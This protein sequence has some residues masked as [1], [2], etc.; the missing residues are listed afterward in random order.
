MKR[1]LLVPFG[2]DQHGGLVSPLEAQKGDPFRCPSCNGV[3]ILEKGEVKVAHCAHGSVRVCSQ[4]T[5]LH[6]TAKMLIAQTVREYLAACG[7]EPVIQGVCSVCEQT[8]VHPIPKVVGVE[9]EKRLSSGFVAGPCEPQGR[10]E[11]GGGIELAFL[12]W[13]QTK[14]LDRGCGY[15]FGSTSL[16]WFA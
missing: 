11:E 10:R 16:R 14:S 5:V 9:I 12:D 6:K 15:R 3:I 13:T 1:E 7:P 2:V 4:E 8:V